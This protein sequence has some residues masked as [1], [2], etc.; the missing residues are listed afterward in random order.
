MSASFSIARGS[1]PN[2]R[3][4]RSGTSSSAC[5]THTADVGDRHMEVPGDLGD[6]LVLRE[7]SA[8]DNRGP[9]AF[10][11]AALERLDDSSPRRFDEHGK[12]PTI[13]RGNEST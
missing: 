8:L 5:V 11:L 3:A 7:K 2:C 1:T 10:G 13:A 6:E 12:Q 9:K 4:Q